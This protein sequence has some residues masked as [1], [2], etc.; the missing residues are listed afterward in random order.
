[1]KHHIIVRVISK[2]L[3]PFMFLFALYVQFHGDFGPGGGFQAGVIFASAIALYTLVWGLDRA[4]QA[5]KPRLI[6]ILIATG[7]MIYGGTGL[8]CLFAGGHL[9]EYRALVEPGH[10]QH[11]EHLGIGLVEFGVGI[12]VTAVLTGIFFAFVRRGRT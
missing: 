3:I 6:E 10:P 4:E 8:L 11:G 7:V 1:M 9:L 12:T 5:F 2:F